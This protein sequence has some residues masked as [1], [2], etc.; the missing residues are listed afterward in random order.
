M[1]ISF[2]PAQRMLLEQL[3]KELA[4]TAAPADASATT[5]AFRDLLP[6]AMAD[7]IAGP[8]TTATAAAKTGTQ[9]GAKR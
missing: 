3:T 5:T 8:A 1:S 7:A 2:D 6:A 9:T 4:K